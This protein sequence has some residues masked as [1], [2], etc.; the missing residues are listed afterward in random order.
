MDA[1]PAPKIEPILRYLAV[2]ALVA[3]SAWLVRLPG[4][5]DV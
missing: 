5:E 4:T 2:A 1:A 3:I